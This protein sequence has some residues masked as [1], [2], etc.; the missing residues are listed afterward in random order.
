[1]RLRRR[2]L[3]RSMADAGSDSAV[4]VRQTGPEAHAA[5]GL[6]LLLSEMPRDRSWRVLDL[7]PAIADNVAALG[8][9]VAQLYVA[10]LFRESTGAVSASALDPLL[11]GPEAVF[12]LVLAWDAIGYLSP[13]PA[14][15]L[16]SQLAGLC[17]RGGRLHALVFAA[18]TMPASPGRY[19]M[20]EDGR[21]SYEPISGDAVGAP[22]L[23]P[24]E[25]EKLLRGFQVDHAFVLSHGVREYVA[26]RRD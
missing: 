10:D 22:Q 18:E 9:R 7:G 20:L 2:A 6:G 23:K 1:M 5:P 19:R 21:L 16:V 4:E 3:S 25:V 13:E 11:S 14:V 17:R 24:A 12:D 26:T 15:R 8:P